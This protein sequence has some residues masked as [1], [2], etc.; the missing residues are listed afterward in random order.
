MSPIEGERYYEKLLL[1]HVRGPTSFSYLMIVNGYKCL[2]FKEAVQKRG[3]LETDQSICDCLN[4]AITLQMPGE[5]RRL[6][7]IIIVH[8]A[9]TDVRVLWNTYFDTLSEDYKREL[10]SIEA[11]ISTTLKSLSFYLE[12]M[13][14]ELIYMILLKYLLHILTLEIVI[15]QERY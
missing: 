8:C 14:K 1:N 11:R 9:P 4:E 6:F 12:S 5:L 2:T 3:L 13:E 10:S 7:A 15:V